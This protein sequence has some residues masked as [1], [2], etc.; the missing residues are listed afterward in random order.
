M[1]AKI[2]SEIISRRRA[3]SLLGLPVAFGVIAPMLVKSSDA[4]AETA[5]MENRQQRRTGQ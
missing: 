5:G 2:K 1:S 4:E 3:L